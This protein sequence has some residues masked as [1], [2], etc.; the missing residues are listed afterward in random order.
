MRAVNHSPPASRCAGER[1]RVR[2]R[3]GV[4][5]M[6]GLPAAAPYLEQRQEEV[7]HGLIGER[8]GDLA[9][10]LH[11]LL[12]HNRLLDAGQGLEG[13]QQAVR[14]RGAA[15]VGHEVAQLL[16]HGQ[17]HLV[18]VVSVLCEEWHQL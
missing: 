13:R 7:D 6:L 15:H 17:Q 11:R 14:E 12:P 10:R 4:G 18:L 5:A 2:R 3:S 16:R 8:G 9:Q 1:R